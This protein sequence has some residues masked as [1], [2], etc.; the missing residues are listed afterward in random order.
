MITRSQAEAEVARELEGMDAALAAGNDGKARVCARRA[1]GAAIAYW[2]QFHPRTGWGIDA[3]SRL[4]G[5]QEENGLPEEVRAAARRLCTRVNE[6]FVH[7]HSSD[8]GSDARAIV[9]ATLNA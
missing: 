7:P 2:L 1:A 8:P 4:R 5:I 9:R 6:Q 3:V